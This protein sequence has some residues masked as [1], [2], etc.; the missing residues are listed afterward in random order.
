MRS[1][2]FELLYK[3]VHLCSVLKPI[4]VFCGWT[5]VLD[6]TDLVGKSDLLNLETLNVSSKVS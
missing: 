6:L 5:L 2:S 1:F 4:S 3:C